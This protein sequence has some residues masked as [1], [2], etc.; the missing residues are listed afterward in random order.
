MF[1]SFF[2]VTVVLLSYLSSCSCDK[3]INHNN[4]KLCEMKNLKC[5]E[6]AQTEYERW[7]CFGKHIY[8]HTDEPNNEG[9]M[10][11]DCG[12]LCLLF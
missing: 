7:N 9:F 2:T 12:K 6:E 5:F 1:L 3:E 10:E 11:H 8:R 4:N